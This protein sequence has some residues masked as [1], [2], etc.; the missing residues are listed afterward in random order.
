MSSASET[1]DSTS[2]LHFLICKSCADGSGEEKKTCA[3]RYIDVGASSFFF[4]VIGLAQSSQS[5]PTDSAD[6]VRK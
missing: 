5:L 1:R 2:G 4:F 6:G 3:L